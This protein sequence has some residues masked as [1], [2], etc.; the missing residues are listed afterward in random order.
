MQFLPRIG[1]GSVKAWI[2]ASLKCCIDIIQHMA[3]WERC[4]DASPVFRRPLDL[5]RHGSARMSPDPSIGR[6]GPCQRIF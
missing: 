2:S 3:C 4:R 6:V 5:G 1:P